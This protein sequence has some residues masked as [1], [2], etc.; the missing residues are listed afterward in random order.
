[1]VLEKKKKK[2]RK[3]IWIALSGCVLLFF[4][5][6]IFPFGKEDVP[7]VEHVRIKKDTLTQRVYGTGVA[8]S[9]E[10]VVLSP[11]ISGEITEVYVGEGQFVRKGDLLFTVQSQ[12]YE[13]ALHRATAELN[14][15]HA[16][17]TMAK[18]R[19][20][21]K[22]FEFHQVQKDFERKKQLYKQ[23][24]LSQADYEIAESKY[25]RSEQDLEIS[26]YEVKSREYSLISSKSFLKEAEENLSL[27][28]IYAPI[29]GTITELM[30][31]PGE[32]VV[33]TRQTQGTDM[34]RISNLDSMIIQLMVHETDISHIRLGN[35]A[36]IRME[37]YAQ[38]RTHLTG[39]IVAISYVPTNLDAKGNINTNSVTEFEVKVHVSP[40]SY[41][42]LPSLEEIPNP[43]R[44]GMTAHVQIIARKKENIWTLP[45][46]SVVAKTDSKGRL[47]EKIFLFQKRK[48]K[49]MDI[50][51]GILEGDRIEIIS[52]NLGTQ[53]IVISGPYLL[54]HKDLKNG[55]EIRLRNPNDKRRK[56][57]NR[58]PNK[59]RDRNSG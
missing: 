26:K 35:Y 45:V 42:K 13:N 31:K 2:Y 27:T 32:R 6:R 59:G 33:G 3:I 5:G 46:E 22:E 47:N 17:L 53:D 21:S 49:S 58:R 43:I 44:P 40:Q 39:K 20:R 48:A 29:H 34:I 37:S 4:L 12:N 54:L 36:E 1:M 24:L 41:E 28:R 23:K 38:L 30:R 15:N 50:Q 25:L 52:S 11:D 18:A 7:I 9:A 51:T 57:N 55:S 19:L 56:K 10:E 14:R 16:N 8:V